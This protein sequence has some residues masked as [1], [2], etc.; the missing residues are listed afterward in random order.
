M[1]VQ[2]IKTLSRRQISDMVNGD[3]D[4]IKAVEALFKL[5]GATT[6]EALDALTEDVNGVNAGL[7]SLTE[8][9]DF[10]SFMP[11]SAPIMQPNEF[12]TEPLTWP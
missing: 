9:V 1:T 12:T 4:A 3:P 2:K 5:A 7:S 10:V 6:P 8:L 11:A